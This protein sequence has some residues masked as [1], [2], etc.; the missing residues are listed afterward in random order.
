MSTDRTTTSG[1]WRA[2][3]D[4][5]VLRHLDDRERRR[6]V[7]V[8]LIPLERLSEEVAASASVGDLAARL[9]VSESALADR[10][11]TLDDDE[12][13]ALAVTLTL[14]SRPGDQREPVP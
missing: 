14:H 12:T 4:H 2:R 11:H 9:G 1:D 5:W 7:A 10:L 3:R 6:Q 13:W 8:A